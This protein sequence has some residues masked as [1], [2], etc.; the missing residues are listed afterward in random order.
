[1]IRN[2]FQR[3]ALLLFCI[4]LAVFPGSTIVVALDRVP[5]W[6]TWMGGALLMLQG[7][8][9]LC[10]LVGRRGARGGL[11]ALLVFGLAWAVE[12]IGVTTGMPFGRYRYTGVLQPQLLGIVPLAIPC[13]WLMVATGAWQIASADEGRTT[14]DERRRTNDEGRTA[15]DEGRRTNGEGRR[16]KD[17]RL[18]FGN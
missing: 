7:G 3:L 16:T 9:A 11:A 5:I 6:G 8:T 12:H 14:K 18:V 13:A 1:M 2:I 17:E 15:K 10:W 4:Y